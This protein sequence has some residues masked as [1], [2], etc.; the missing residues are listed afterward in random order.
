MPNTSSAGNA[1]QNGLQ[2][3]NPRQIAIKLIPVAGGPPVRILDATDEQFE[4]F[5]KQVG[6]VVK[7]GD[8]GEKWS[9]DNRCRAINFALK[10]GRYLPF[11]ES[12][13]EQKTIPGVAREV[14]PQGDV[15]DRT[16]AIVRANSTI[17]DVE[18]ASLLGL[19]RPA[20]A[21][22]WRIKAFEILGWLKDEHPLE[23]ATV[24]T[25]GR[26]YPDVSDEGSSQ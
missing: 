15:L 24:P 19:K 3:L 18:L 17:D 6:I 13:E 10:H 20:S 4:A 14:A 23:P 22:F 25:G 26:P 2:R 1:E 12:S 5:I 16:V 7:A 9:F 21:R 11:V 8:E